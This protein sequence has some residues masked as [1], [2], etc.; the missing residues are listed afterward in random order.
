[1]HRYA[2]DGF[3]A[4]RRGTAQTDGISALNRRDHVGLAVRV[5]LAGGT[6][7]CWFVNTRGETVAVYNPFAE[8]PARMEFVLELK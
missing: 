1:M 6:Q 7:T 4:G 5:D 3:I 2:F 8:G